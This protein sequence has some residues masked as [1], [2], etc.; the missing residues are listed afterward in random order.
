MEGEKFSHVT[1]DD[2]GILII[3]IKYRLIHRWSVNRETYL[4]GLINP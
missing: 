4:L 1:L 2:V 3:S